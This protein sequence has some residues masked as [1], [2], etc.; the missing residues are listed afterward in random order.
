MLYKLSKKAIKKPF[1]LVGL[2]LVRRRSPDSVT[3]LPPLFDDPL[4]ALCY[5]QGGKPAAFQC[6]IRHT[7]NQNGLSYSP[8]G[9]HPFVATL[10][11]YAAGEITGYEGSILEEFYERYQPAHA[12]A[13]IAGFAR[14]PEVYTRYPA[15]IYRLAPWKS[16]T[17]EEEDRVVRGW[18]EG[19]STEHGG[20]ERGWTLDA[21]GYPYHGPV[22]LRR[23]QLEYERLVRTWESLRTV[24]YD[25]SM[26]HA[27]FVMLRRGDERRFLGRGDGS[28][29]TAA[30]SALGHARIPAVFLES[31][32][33]DIDMAA[34]WPQVKRGIWTEEE[35]RAYF[36][37][38]FDF[39]SRAWALKEG[40]IEE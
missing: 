24:G 14:A 39:D 29:R 18:S 26:G 36:N 16:R 38:L 13:A 27:C 1:H 10:H 2:D 8:R 21:D 19:D 9:W 17:P 37:H 11:E 30:M 20:P 22:S 15:H 31:H 34:S 3:E 25:R 5:Q 12:A 4:E 7:C 40:F 33:V 32:M 35:A 6:P 28:H 23:G